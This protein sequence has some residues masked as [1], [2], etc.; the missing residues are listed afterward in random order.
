MFTAVV[1][2]FFSQHTFAQKLFSNGCVSVKLGLP[3]FYDSLGNNLK[4]TIGLKSR[5]VRIG[6]ERNFTSRLMYDIGI[7]RQD[8]EFYDEEK[9]HRSGYL[10]ALDMG[11]RLLLLKSD[12]KLQPYIGVGYA[13]A[14]TKSYP[15]AKYNQWLQQTNTKAGVNFLMR[16]LFYVGYN[17]DFSFSLNQKIAYNG[18]H[19]LGVTVPISS[20]TKKRDTRLDSLTNV[21]SMALN[22]NEDLTSK[23]NDA[24]IEIEKMEEDLHF[25]NNVNQHNEKLKEEVERLRINRDSIIQA[26]RTC[27]SLKSNTENL[28]ELPNN[29][30]AGLAIMEFKDLAPG[31]YFQTLPLEKKLLADALNKIDKSAVDAIQLVKWT[32]QYYLILYP[33][34]NQKEKV[35]NMLNKEILKDSFTILHIP[36]HQ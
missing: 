6:Y 35:I 9:G 23:I 26:L 7:G 18:T 33:M 2:I 21:I 3:S 29:I 4:K 16:D 30:P 24:K 22:T 10:S 11:V 36:S 15:Q 13:L 28:N 5:G 14:K 1:L 12:K 25:K 31:F 8:F 27:D 34:G 20:F 17:Y 32:E 19:F